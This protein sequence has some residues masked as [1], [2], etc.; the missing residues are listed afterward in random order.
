MTN[1][2]ENE[3]D[4]I[5]KFIG[6]EIPNVLFHYTSLDCIV[7]ILSNKEIWMS[8][9]Y[10]L[11]D[12]NEFE[13]GLKL[14]ENELQFQKNGLDIV[15][16]VKIFL[17]AIEKLIAYIKEKDSP[18][19]FALTKNNDQLS[20]WRAY[21]TN[22]VGINLGFTKDFFIQNSLKVFPCIYDIDI[23]KKFIRHIFDTAVLLFVGQSDRLNLLGENKKNIDPNLFDEPITIAGNY[24]INR[25]IL[26][27]GLIKDSNFHEEEEWR[28]LYV[29]KKNSVHFLPK[30]NYL[31]PFVKMPFKNRD[32]S[33]SCITVGPNSDAE[34]C[35][36]SI[37]KLLKYLNLQNIKIETS[38]IPYRNY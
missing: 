8:N 27:C 1:I 30:N 38:K 16:S 6:K 23:Q 3:F 18:Y 12:K 22:G 28:V 24:F 2:T 26:A 19:I 7:G 11:N 5:S 33:L 32:T 15:P 10:F 14:I 35:S 4:E 37:K 21:S 20:Q 25:V 34:L 29:N 17:Q 31:K 36:L 13:L 9:M